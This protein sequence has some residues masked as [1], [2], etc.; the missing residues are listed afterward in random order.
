MVIGLPCREADNHTQNIRT[1]WL[2]GFSSGAIVPKDAS[3]FELAS[4]QDR[5]ATILM[6]PV[7]AL[8]EVPDYERAR[9]LRHFTS[10]Y[11]SRQVSMCGEQDELSTGRQMICLAFLGPCEARHVDEDE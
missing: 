9:V 10:K 5:L 6:C 3:Q 2:D 4:G 11:T 8:Y 1:G 7:P